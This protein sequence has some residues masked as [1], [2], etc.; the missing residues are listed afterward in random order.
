MDNNDRYLHR[1]IA[2][3]IEHIEN[4]SYGLAVGLLK[5]AIKEDKGKVREGDKDGGRTDSKS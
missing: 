4:G 5:S 3:A 2:H 1:E